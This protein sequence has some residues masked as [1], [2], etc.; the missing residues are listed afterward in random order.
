MP[1]IQPI[2]DA[3]KEDGLTLEALR[4]RLNGV[5]THMDSA[6]LEAALHRMMFSAELSGQ[7]PPSDGDA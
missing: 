7:T 5:F 3:T 1:V 6:E 4:D 2:L